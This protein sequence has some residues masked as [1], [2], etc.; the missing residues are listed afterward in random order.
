[1]LYVYTKMIREKKPHRN[2]RVRVDIT[3]KTVFSSVDV[4]GEHDRWK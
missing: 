3:V 1:M 4:R 2:G